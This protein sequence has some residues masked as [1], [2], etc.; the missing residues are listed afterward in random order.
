MHAV[1]RNAVLSSAAIGVSVGGPG[2]AHGARTVRVWLRS[3]S[4]LEAWTSVRRPR[5]TNARQAVTPAKGSAAAGALE[6]EHHAAH[7][8]TAQHRLTAQLDHPQPPT[9]C[10][11]E[12]E[13]HVV[14]G[15]RHATPFSHTRQPAHHGRVQAATPPAANGHSCAGTHERAGARGGEVWTAIRQRPDS[16]WSF[17]RVTHRSETQ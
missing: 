11:I 17:C 12:H 15:D 4:R 1:L 10:G 9:G 8:V 7:V 13:Q 5:V 3:R 6:L 16:N 2:A 14:S